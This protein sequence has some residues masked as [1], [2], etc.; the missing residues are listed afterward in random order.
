MLKKNPT[1][2]NIN[3]SMDI[4]N[5]YVEHLHTLEIKYKLLQQ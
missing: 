2:Q 4:I 5:K 1:I 3:N